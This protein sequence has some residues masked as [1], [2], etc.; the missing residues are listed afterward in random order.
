M[1]AARLQRSRVIAE[2][3]RL[4]KRVPEDVS[5]IGFD[6]L[7]ICAYTSPPLTTIRQDRIQLGKSAYFALSTLMDKVSIGMLLLHAQLIERGSTGE[8]KAFG[9]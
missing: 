7:P 6:D 1:P 8:R 3:K 4:G 2:L 9:T 5:V